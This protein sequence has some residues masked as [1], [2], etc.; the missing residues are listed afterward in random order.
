MVRLDCCSLLAAAATALHNIWIDGA[1]HQKLCARANTPRLAFENANEARANAAAL[2]F[3]V[4][5]ILQV[6]QKLGAC[7]N[8]CKVRTK[9][10]ECSHHL[11]RFICAHQ[12][13][14]HVKTIQLATQCALRQRHGHG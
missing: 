14:V 4:A 3:R 5:N 13:G 9:I 11:S 12:T 2:F 8:S 7:I 10:L 1:L 6:G